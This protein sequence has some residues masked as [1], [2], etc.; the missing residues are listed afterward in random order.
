MEN[1]SYC[2]NRLLYDRGPS[3]TF[4][5]L[6]VNVG[7]FWFFLCVFNHVRKSSKSS[8]TSRLASLITAAKCVST[9]ESICFD[10]PNKSV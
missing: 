1:M 6:K 4:D 7:F 8:K 5:S 9:K 3:D 2:F 10:N